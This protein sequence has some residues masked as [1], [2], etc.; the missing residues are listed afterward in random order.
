MVALLP[1]QNSQVAEATIRKGLLLGS[2]AT[3]DGLLCIAARGMVGGAG[4]L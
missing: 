1:E 4:E 3:E 2:M